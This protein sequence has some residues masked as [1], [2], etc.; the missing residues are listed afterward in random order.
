[1]LIRPAET[2]DCASI[3]A[4]WAPVVRDTLV[5]FNPV[6]KSAD[7]I[8]ALLTASRTSDH[9]FLVA[10]QAGEVAGFVR[11]AQF[12]GGQ[13]Y[14]RTMEHTIML[15]A[16]ARGRGLGRMLME[17]VEDHARV[18]GVHSMMAGVSGANP[19]GLRF[20]AALGYS[21][22]ARLPEVGFKNG[23]YLDLILMQRML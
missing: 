4:I 9:G 21:Q 3:A 2:G 8:E 16:E 20:H 23:R 10:E 14:A 6:A 12:R 1:M 19:A 7:D 5:T 15:C 13:G 17:A 11:Y 22:V 18:R